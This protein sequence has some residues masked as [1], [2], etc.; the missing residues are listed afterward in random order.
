MG[1]NLPSY[2]RPPPTPRA[3][4]SRPTGPPRAGGHPR[5][6]PCR[7]AAAGARRA[8]KGERPRGERSPGRL[9][10]KCIPSDSRNWGTCIAYVVYLYMYTH[11][12][13]Y[14]L[15]IC[16][17]MYAQCTYVCI[18]IYAFQSPG[19]LPPPRVEPPSA[20]SRASWG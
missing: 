1:Y 16:I 12:Y 7:C 11:V 2:P 20:S 15:Y 3:F 14:G 18:Y 6:A 19:R 9:S 5:R 4:L 13:R 17:Y 8:P 10:V